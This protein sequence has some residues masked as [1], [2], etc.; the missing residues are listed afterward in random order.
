MAAPSFSERK[1]EYQRLFDSLAMRKEKFDE[2]DNDINKILSH[3]RV[4]EAVGEPLGVPWFVV[5]L[6]HCM[7]GSGNLARRLQD[8]ARLQESDDPELTWKE[9][10]T[11]TLISQGFDKWRDWSIPGLFY[12]IEQYNGWGYYFRQVNSAYLWSFSNHYTSGKYVKDKVWSAAAVSQQ[13]G[14]AV[15]MRRLLDRGLVSLQPGAAT[16]QP[17]GPEGPAP[18]PA[19]YLIQEGDTLWAIARRFRVSLDKLIRG[20]P[21]ISDPDLIHPGDRITIPGEE[22]L[23]A[24]EPPVTPPGPPPALTQI[25]T[26]RPGDTLKSIAADFATTAAHLLEINPQIISP[27]EDLHVPKKIQPPLE[28]PYTAPGG[29]P[30]WLKIAEQEMQLMVRETPD[31]ATSNPR[32]LEYHRSTYGRAS[33]EE[34]AWCSAFVNWCL[35]KAEAEGTKSARAV[36]WLKWGKE[37]AA[38]RLGCIAVFWRSAN[39]DEGHVGFYWGEEDEHILLLG[40]NQHDAV[41][42][43]RQAKSNLRDHGY[44]WPEEA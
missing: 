3:R 35:E 27:G 39:P 26:V 9:S 15:I 19:T 17:P 18:P 43:E 4:Y 31:R 36:S 12:K 37:M 6:I 7:E 2:I 11:R 42:I 16:P 25:Y 33:S 34:V 22:A 23:P 5:G 38:P 20:N 8:G 29:K 13:A 24:E 28:I 44:R 1:E 32:I 41:N 14:A 21:Q 40:G 10:S 30:R